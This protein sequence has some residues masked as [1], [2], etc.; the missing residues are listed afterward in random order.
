MSFGR[1]SFEKKDKAPVPPSAPA[2]SASPFSDNYDKKVEPHA[3]RLQAEIKA[4]GTLF[5]RAKT[6]NDNDKEKFFHVQPN[7]YLPTTQFHHYEN[8][9]L[10]KAVSELR[11]KLEKDL[12]AKD[13]SKEFEKF[14]HEV[15][16]HFRTLIEHGH[17]DA[18]AWN[19]TINDAKSSVEIAFKDAINNLKGTEEKKNEETKK[20]NDAKTERLRELN[21]GIRLQQLE[22]LGKSLERKRF[23]DASGLA[24]AE[25]LGHSGGRWELVS[26]PAK[27]SAAMKADASSGGLLPGGY[28]EKLTEG[29]YSRGGCDVVVMI[30]KNGVARPNRVPES[31]E[32]FHKA[33]KEVADL[34]SVGKGVKELTVT[35]S[36]PLSP[37]DLR[38]A[39]RMIELADETKY[40][41]RTLPITG[42]DLHVETAILQGPDGKKEFK[43]LSD[44]LARRKGSIDDQERTYR[45]AAGAE[46][47]A[48]LDKLDSYIDNDMRKNNRDETE[49]K[50]DLNDPKGT[51]ETRLKKLDDELKA[52]E[53]DTA[54]LDRAIRRVNIQY[55]EVLQKVEEQRKATPPDPAKLTDLEKE[56]GQLEKRIEN[57]GNEH[58][59]IRTYRTALND[60]NKKQSASASSDTFNK[61][62]TE[63]ESRLARMETSLPSDNLMKALEKQLTEVK[64]AVPSAAA[65]PSIKS[66]S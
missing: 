53:T 7:A 61:N 52:T 23:T 48:A 64:A 19:T 28:A 31:S 59:R 36:S 33:Y 27:E 34:L 38:H 4:Y 56:Y 15:E 40:P 13:E 58:K 9:P 3:Q 10:S 22:M 8:E 25:A 43:R 12:N 55:R 51:L 30:D 62:L 21:E 49:L 24:R 65:T 32:E 35:F 39:I 29:N 41:G 6:F 2:P 20:L 60:E 14:S 57:I 26:A 18:K 1:D 63:M 44:I 46:N 42:M 45:D 54:Q 17:F 37:N 11:T 47:K 16:T 66:S 50:K 5:Q